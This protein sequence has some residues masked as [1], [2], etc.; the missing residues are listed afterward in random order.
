MVAMKFVPCPYSM[1]EMSFQVQGGQFWGHRLS[2]RPLGVEATVTLRDVGSIQSLD[3]GGDVCSGPF[4]RLLHMEH[5]RGNA[6][7]VPGPAHSESCG[8]STPTAGPRGQS[9]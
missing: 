1:S 5:S 8:T 2:P 6:P 4:L 9:P 7:W 3:S